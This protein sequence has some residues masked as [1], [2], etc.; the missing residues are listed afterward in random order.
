MYLSA[1][2]LRTERLESR[3]RYLPHGN[4]RRQLSCVLHIL[5]VGNMDCTDRAPS[6]P[7]WHELHGCQIRQYAH[8]EQAASQS[9]VLDLPRSNDRV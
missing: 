8:A 3:N 7:S 6:H 2:E 4:A 1:A 9:R 5:P